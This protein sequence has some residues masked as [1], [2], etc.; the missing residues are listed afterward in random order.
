MRMPGRASPCDFHAA[1]R[2]RFGHADPEAPIEIVAFGATAIG[3]VDTPELPAL[4]A[5]GA[6]PPAEAHAATRDVFFEGD[7]P[8]A[9]RRLDRGSDIRRAR[10][11]LQT[12]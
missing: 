6:A 12:T 9:G 7:A 11:C 4:A 10:S 2:H 5:G 8:G 1:H 3:K